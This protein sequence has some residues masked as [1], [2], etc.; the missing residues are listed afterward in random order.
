MDRKEEEV[1]HNRAR[2][3]G[4]GGTKVKERGRRRKKQGGS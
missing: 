2:K 1:R 4:E 3:E